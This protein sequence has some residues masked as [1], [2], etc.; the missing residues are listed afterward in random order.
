MTEVNKRKRLTKA[1]FA[2]HLFLFFPQI[3]KKKMKRM[4]STTFAFKTHINK[5][6]TTKSRNKNSMVQST[7]KTIEEWEMMHLYLDIFYVS[8]ESLSRT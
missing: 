4:F 5:E 6:Q 1:S 7:W 2:H 3:L 8:V